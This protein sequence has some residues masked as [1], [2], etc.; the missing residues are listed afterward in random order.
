M[1]I[2]DDHFS[3]GQSLVVVAILLVVLIGMLALVLD[4]GYAYLQRRVAQTAADAGALA[5]AHEL[6]ETGDPN[7]ALNRA[8]EYAIDRNGATLANVVVDSGV[9]TV[10]TEITFSTFFGRIF[11]RAEITAA[12][13]AAAKCT[14]AGA[15]ANILPIAWN[16]PPDEV[17]IDADGTWH[18]K[19]Q[20]GKEHPIII[21]QSDRI[22][23]DDCIS[24]GGSVNCD[25]DNDGYDELK[26]GGNRSWLYLDEDGGGADALIG[27]V[28]DGFDGKISIHTWFPGKGGVADSIFQSIKSRLNQ[29]VLLPVYN[30][31]NEGIPPIPWGDDPDCIN[32]QIVLNNSFSAT[33]YHVIAFS[34]F[35][36]TCVKAIGNDVCPLHD[37]YKAE[38]ILKPQD[39]TI[40]GYFVDGTV[41]G[42]DGGGSV[43]AGVYVLTLIR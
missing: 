15:A 37:A 24:H 7:L 27:W 23:E 30:A 18:C 26:T 12:A 34:I 36:P 3:K 31:R 43:Y 6:C 19:M 10:D 16:C 42:V 8:L 41:D 33:Y 17:T 13:I 9:V 28:E 5:G 39:K 22:S 29:E 2:D 20:F 25:I 14:P 38:G 40:E 11:D 4:G 21:M 32:D 35:V 1:N